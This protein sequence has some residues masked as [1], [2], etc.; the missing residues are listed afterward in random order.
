MQ[1]CWYGGAGTEV[2]LQLC[3]YGGAGT[4]M[5][6]QWCWYRGAVTVVLVQ[7]GFMFGGCLDQISAEMPTV[8]RYLVIA[9][10]SSRQMRHEDLKYST[11]SFF[12]NLHSLIIQKFDTI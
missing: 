5:L 9:I 8:L 2:L 6:L 11:I 12:P 3:W 1:R 10:I 7:R 4:E